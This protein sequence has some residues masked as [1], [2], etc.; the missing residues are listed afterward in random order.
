MYGKFCYEVRISEVECGSPSGQAFKPNSLKGLNATLMNN[1]M[2]NSKCSEFESSMGDK[3]DEHQDLCKDGDRSTEDGNEIMARSDMPDRIIG[4]CPI[5]GESVTGESNNEMTVKALNGAQDDGRKS[6]EIEVVSTKVRGST[7]QTREYV[8]ESVEVDGVNIW[9]NKKEL[10]M[11]DRK[12]TF[13]S[14]ETDPISQTREQIRDGPIGALEGP[15]G[16]KASACPKTVTSQPCS[17]GGSFSPKSKKENKIRKKVVKSMEKI[18]DFLLHQVSKKIGAKGRKL[19]K[20][21]RNKKRDKV[22]EMIA[23]DSLT[24][25][26]FQNKQRI[27][28]QEAVETW[29]LGKLLGCS[30]NGD[31]E[32]VIDILMH[33]EEKHKKKQ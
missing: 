4:N 1:M 11:Y 16:K 31:E 23:N 27:L 5:E 13:K 14:M 21:K 30:V 3:A 17:N 20:V 2:S 22:N 10:D 15:I 26:D 29:E 19:R 6:N 8:S 33:L 18:E 9:A 32:E 24:D 12:L 28:R 7:W 25:G